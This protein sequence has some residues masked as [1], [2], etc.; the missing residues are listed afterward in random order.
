M[1]LGTELIGVQKRPLIHFKGLFYELDFWLIKCLNIFIFSQI[2][3]H[4]HL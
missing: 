3:V 1:G 4:V 2:H